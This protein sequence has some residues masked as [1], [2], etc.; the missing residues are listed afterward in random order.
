MT[1]DE[2]SYILDSIAQIKV[3]TH[4]NNQILSQLC[5]VVNVYL[6]NH[7]KENE[8]DFGRNVLANII[9]NQFIDVGNYRK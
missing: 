9:S 4:H 8:D 6:A 3:E 1:Y 7:Q 2:E 5:H